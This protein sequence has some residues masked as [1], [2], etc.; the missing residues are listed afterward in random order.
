MNNICLTLILELER[1]ESDVS[2]LLSLRESQDKEIALELTKITID[3]IKHRCNCISYCISKLYSSKDSFKQDTSDKTISGEDI[4]V[5]L[6]SNL[7]LKVIL[8]IILNKNNN[9]ESIVQIL[10]KLKGVNGL[11]NDIDS[12]L[13]IVNKIEINE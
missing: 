13:E 11:D 2:V 3:T 5:G 1:L 9:L 12:L 4:V 7:L 6:V 10:D 8:N